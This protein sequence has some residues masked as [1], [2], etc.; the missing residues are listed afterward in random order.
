MVSPLFLIHYSKAIL[1]DFRFSSLKVKM[2]LSQAF[3]FASLSGASYFR[4][5]LPQI[6]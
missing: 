2:M 6:A 3:C 5:K 4:E 1:R